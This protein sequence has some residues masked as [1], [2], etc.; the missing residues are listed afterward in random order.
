MLSLL[1]YA[2]LP[3]EDFVL[4]ICFFA[5]TLM[6]L[7]PQRIIF[8]VFFSTYVHVFLGGSRECFA[9]TSKFWA[10]FHIMSWRN[11]RIGT[12]K[13]LKGK[14]SGKRIEK[15][16]EAKRDQTRRNPQKLEQENSKNA[17]S[18]SLKT[19]HKKIE[20]LVRRMNTR[21]IDLFQCVPRVH[22]NNS[23]GVKA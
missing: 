18:D 9:P 3:R 22:R 14:N 20:K 17:I 5:S 6:C 23:V 10:I 1:Y 11:K 13:R 16:K 7:S 4:V 2:L 12:K 15:R 19:C 21:D 8:P